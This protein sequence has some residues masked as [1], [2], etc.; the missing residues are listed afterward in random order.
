MLV[1]SR[2]IGEEVIIA[3]Q[4]RVRIVAVSGKRVRLA[5]AAPQSVA[6][7]RAEIYYDRNELAL[8]SDFAPVDEFAPLGEF[9][10]EV[11]ESPRNGNP[12]LVRSQPRRLAG[13]VAS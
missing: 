12:A 5:I 9:V 6:V 10:A 2:R 8:A 7:H 3:G 1:L 13:R 4:V 11:P